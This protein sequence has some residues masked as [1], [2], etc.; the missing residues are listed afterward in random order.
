MRAEPQKERR[1]LDSDTK[2]TTKLVLCDTFSRYHPSITVIMPD[3]PETTTPTEGDQSG[4]N[5]EVAQAPVKDV[6]EQQAGTEPEP[7]E[8]P[9]GSDATKPENCGAPGGGDVAA[10]TEPASLAPEEKKS[11]DDVAL[12]ADKK[13]SDDHVHDGIASIPTMKSFPENLYEIVADP[14][15]D[16]IVSWLPHGRGFQI[17]DKLRFGKEILPKYFEGAKFTR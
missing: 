13:S 11:S 10:Q 17:T 14:A 16:D 15:T 12:S 4:S 8:N 1:P 3:A 7:V 9:A 6:N 2:E 5:N